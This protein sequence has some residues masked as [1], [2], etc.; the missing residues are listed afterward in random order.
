MILLT[1]ATGFVG[2]A[3]VTDLLSKA[4]E[5]KALVRQSTA[6]LPIVCCTCSCERLGGFD[7][8]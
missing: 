5:V 4:V 3:L 7:V 1:G 8:E 2:K 6:E